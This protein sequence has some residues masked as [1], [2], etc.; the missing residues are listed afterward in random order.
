MRSEKNQRPSHA[1]RP[2][3]R[4]SS[5]PVPRRPSRAADAEPALAS[6]SEEISTIGAGQ[7]ARVTTRKNAAQAADRARHNAEKRYLKRHPEARPSQVGPER[8]RRNVVLLVV[9]AVLALALVLLLARCVA[10]LLT[11]DPAQQAQQAAE[12]Q[13]NEQNL[14]TGDDV[15]QEAESEQVSTDGS[16]SYQGSSFALAVQDDG[17]WGVVRTFSDGTSQ[18][19]FEV[20]GTPFSLVRH[21]S[22]L[23]VPE[24][25][26]GGWDVVCFVIDGA[27]QPA[28]VVNADGDPVG[29]QG[30]VS[31]VDVGDTGLT[32]S[33]TTG[34]TTDV[35]LA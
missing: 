23:L 27:S 10:A 11:P 24:N 12:E 8:S 5:A 22:T 6:S 28:Y 9:L 1:E 20:E 7:G 35:P 29:G 3:R 4:P 33:D 16:L 31:S 18:T 30:D 34:A 26:D 2:S 17:L 15:P 19:I 13:R 32:V 14:S 21:G 25:R